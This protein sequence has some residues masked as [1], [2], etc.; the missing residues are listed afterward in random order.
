MSEFAAAE[1][2]VRQCQARYIDAV[3]RMD[4]VAFADCFTEDAEWRVPAFADGR[5]AESGIVD[6]VIKGRAACVEFFRESC[7]PFDRIYM[8]LNTPILKVNGGTAIGRTYVTERNA[9]KDK[10]PFYST[11]IYYDRFIQ[12]GERWRYGLHHFQLQFMGAPDMKGEFMKVKDYGAPFG[13][14]A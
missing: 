11:A 8:T 5:T 3:W 7:I 12:Q 10:V 1:A 13:M 2:G 14:P 4:F 6:S 9:R